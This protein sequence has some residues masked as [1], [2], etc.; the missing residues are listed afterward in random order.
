MNKELIVSITIVLIFLGVVIIPE[1]CS[2]PSTF[3]KNKDGPPITP[4][5]D[6]DHF[7]CGYEFWCYHACLILEDGQRWDATASFVYFMNKT[8]EGYEPGLSFL[9]IRHWN[10]QTEE[11][12]DYLRFDEY[13]GV[14]QTKKNQVNLTYGNSFA[15]G[16]YPNYFFH[17][18][19]LTNNIIIDINLHS[20]SYPAWVLEEATNG[21]IPW[22]LSGTGMAYFIP[23]INATGTIDINGTIYNFTGLAYIEHDFADIN[24]GNP[25]AIYSLKEAITGIRL[26]LNGAKWL[27]SQ[28][29]QNRWKILPELH[30]SSDYLLGWGWNWVAF[31]NSWSIVIFRPT[32]L[33]IAEGYVPI[34]LYFTKDGI[35]Y[36]EIG[37]V[38]WKNN[39]ENYMERVDIYIPI[40]FEITAR[41]DDIELYI[42]FNCTTEVTELYTTDLAPYSSADLACSFYWCGTVK[43]YY[44]DKGSNIPLSGTY[45]MEQSRMMTKAKHRSRDIEIILPPDGLGFR[46]KKTSHL[47]GFERYF[48]IMLRPRFKI[49]FYIRS[50]P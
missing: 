11:C 46:I 9:R 12:Y 28:N 49:D 13:P 42:I 10:K 36:S 32:I 30:I 38:Y 24:F 33:S 7:P 43:G 8:K 25:F 23:I 27:L 6:G 37:Y 15:R 22:G 29:L 39:Y 14:F 19:D 3:R 18:E 44:K 26:M 50:T 34:F 40:D 17:C 21:I 4:E 5:D 47:L 20:I 31:D 41:I 2:I 35:N 48:E 16:L 45:G 1:G